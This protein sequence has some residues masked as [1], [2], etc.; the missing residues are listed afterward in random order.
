MEQAAEG[1]EKI[2]S[3]RVADILDRIAARHGKGSETGAI[4]SRTA[5]SIRASWLVE[6][7]EPEPKQVRLPPQPPKPPLRVSQRFVQ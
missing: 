5:D 3:E 2:G 1:L 6:V 4:A 7:A